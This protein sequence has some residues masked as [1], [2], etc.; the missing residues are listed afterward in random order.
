MKTQWATQVVSWEYSSA[1]TPNLKDIPIQPFPASL[2]EQGQTRVIALDLSQELET[3]YLATTPNL[4]A[5]YIR[6]QKDE[7]I[8][9]AVSA[10]SEVFFVLRGSGRTETDEG[11][12]TW[13]K[14]DAFTL[15]CNQ[16]VTHFADEDTAFF[17]AHDAPL[18]QYLGVSPTT[19]KF[20]PAFYSQKYMMDEVERIREIAMR[21][22]RNRVGIILG[23]VAHQKNK[24]MTHTLWS[25]F[26]LLPKGAVQK[27]H[28]HQS[29]AIDLAVF[30]AENTY[31]LI[32]KEVDEQGEVM[33]PVKAVW[34]SNTIFV[35]PPGW[36]HSHHN[37]SN[38]NAYVFPVQ[39]AG[40]H[41]YMRTLDIQFV[42]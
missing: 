34:E 19:A 37:E 11:T 29:V 4:L 22:N 39:D 31:T 5:N 7:Q 6:I 35:T 2:H 16:G 40:L 26:N 23:N 21:E 32:G 24:S 27:P 30:A 13:Q 25:L 33:N 28:R 38:E 15:A 41:S 9:T 42:R 12:L 3:P 17:W 8:K 14:G 18:L 1:A 10:T 36:W 20:K